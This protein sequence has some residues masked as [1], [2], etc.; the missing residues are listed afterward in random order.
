MNRAVTGLSYL[1]QLSPWKGSGSFSLKAIQ[2]VLS[3]LGD[4]QEAYGVIHVG[5][6]NGKGSVSVATASILARAGGKVGLT[7]SPHLSHVNER[8]VID[9]LPVNDQLLGEFALDVRNAAYK[10][11]VDLTFHEAMTAIAFLAF[12]ETEVALAVVEV[13][14]GGRLDSSNVVSRP[15]VTAIVTVDYD[16]QQILGDTLGEIATEKAGIIKSSCIHITGP[17][18]REAGAVITRVARSQKAR[19]MRFGVDYGGRLDPSNPESFVYWRKRPEPGSPEE[20]VVSPTLPGRHQFDN[21]AVAMTIGRCL[22]LPLNACKAGIEGVFWPGRL[23]YQQVRNRQFVI[24]CAHNPAG[25]RSLTSFLDSKGWRDLDLVF[26]VLDTKSWQSMVAQLK[27]Y[28]RT[29]HLVLPQSERAL[30][31]QMLREEIGISGIGVSVRE[32]GTDVE[33]CLASLYEEG[34]GPVVVAGSMYMTGRFRELLDIA[35]RS[36]WAK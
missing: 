17:V 11:F 29:W 24:D 27:K 4:P 20:I 13:G 19:E 35:P 3:R 14:L 36:L 16:H 15:L 5:G 31:S 25:I 22:E 8:I 10:A 30:P 2:A 1:N 7:I 18:G 9:G 21:M 26:G 33:R 32:Y 34:D 23:E 6:T 28:V 12:R